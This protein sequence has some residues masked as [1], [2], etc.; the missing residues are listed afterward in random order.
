MIN[1]EN[2]PI[3][4]AAVMTP[5]HT[6]S[7]VFSITDP[8]SRLY[9]A[10]YFPKSMK[11]LSRD[12]AFEIAKNI[13]KEIEQCKYFGFHFSWEDEEGKGLELWRVSDEGCKQLLQIV[14]D[15]GKIKEYYK[16]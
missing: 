1:L 9:S 10:K 14:R 5:A 12:E 11:D 7:I 3:L 13:K 4:P 8:T 16:G 15:D 6:Y 2:A